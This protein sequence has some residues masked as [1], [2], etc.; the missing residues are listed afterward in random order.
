MSDSSTFANDGDEPRDVSALVAVQPGWRTSKF[1]K[2]VKDLAEAARHYPPR[3]LIANVVAQFD[4][5]DVDGIRVPIS[6]NNAEYD[7][8]ASSSEYAAL[9][10][11]ARQELAH[12]PPSWRRTSANLLLVVGGTLLRLVSIDRIVR[13]FPGALAYDIPPDATLQFVR[14]ATAACVAAY[15]GHAVKWSG[16]N[17]VLDA[18]T[19]MALRQSGYLIRASRP[20]YVLLAEPQINGNLIRSAKL[21]ARQTETSLEVLR[22]EDPS[23]FERIAELYAMV[24]LRPGRRD[25]IAFTASAFHELHR[26]GAL[27]ICVA[28]DKA[29]REIRAFG[30]YSARD[31]CLAF[32]HV[33]YDPSDPLG[34]DHYVGLISSVQ[35]AAR[36]LGMSARIGFGAGR[37]KRARGAVGTIEFSACYVAHL[38]F[39]HRFAW[40][41]LTVMINWQAPPLMLALLDKDAPIGH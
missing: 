28:R 20:A 7:N 33:G 3:A 14:R 5:L 29:S 41:V 23:A 8:S 24:N 32:H 13:L 31:G 30:A 19:Y 11:S 9:T 36:R 18:R 39:W 17:P 35:L 12:A 27:Q 15:P 26:V 21:Y 22:T 6:V 4:W 37:F 1:A 40:R 34:R 10:V 25:N 38:R 16:I 2:M